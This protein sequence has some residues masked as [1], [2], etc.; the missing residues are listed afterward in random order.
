MVK[1]TKGFKGL[2]KKVLSAIL[3]ASMI[4]TS[5]SFVMAAEPTPEQENAI[6]TEA[7]PEVVD[8]DAATGRTNQKFTKEDVA[9][10]PAIYN[11]EVQHPKVTVDGETEDSGKFHVNYVGDCVNAGTYKVEIT[12]DGDWSGT[13]A[14]EKEFTIEKASI[15][16]ADVEVEAADTFEYN[17]TSQ[18][19]NVVV[20]TTLGSGDEA[21]DYV[22]QDDEYV[23]TYGSDDTGDNKG[24]T[25]GTYTITITA[26]EDSNFKDS[27]TTK[28]EYKIVQTEMSDSLVKVEAEDIP[29]ADFDADALKAAVTVTDIGLD[30]ALEKDEYT[31]TVEDEETAGD[32]GT[33]SFVIE[34]TVNAQ[35]YAGGEVKGQYTVVA[36]ESFASILEGVV[37][38]T[39]YSNAEET[40]VYAEAVENV[41]EQ[42]ADKNV[43]ESEYKIIT[44]ESDWNNV[45]EYTLVVEGQQIYDGQTAEIKVTVSPKAITTNGTDLNQG[46]AVSV[47]QGTHPGSGELSE[48]VVTVTDNKVELVEGTDYV[49]KAVEE[50]GKKYVEITGIGNYTTENKEDKVEVYTKEYTVSKKMY[51]ADPSIY[52][53]VEK[54][55]IAYT[56][57]PITL[58]NSDIVLT[59]TDGSDVI[60]LRP[61]KDYYIVD[62]SYKNNTAPGTATVTVKGM[63]DYTG[64]ITVEFEI[65]GTSFADSFDVSMKK[66]SFAMD[67]L[68]TV[69]KSN[70]V[71]RAKGSTGTY[72]KFDVEYLKD[73]ETYK[74]T[75][76]EPGAYV[77][78]VTS[79]EEKYSGYVDLDFIVLGE[80]VDF[81]VS[82]VEDQVYTGAQ[83]TPAVTVTSKDG[84]TTYKAGE[85]YEVVYG[86]N[87][88]AG[89]NA[90]TVTVNMI[91]EYSGSSTVYFNITKADQTITMTN[92][93]QE[94]DLANGTRTTTSKNCTLKLGFGVPDTMNLSYESSDKSVATVNNGV[95]TYQG[96]GECTI[97]VTA[98]ETN[99][100]KAVSL[101]ITVKVGKVGTPTFTPSVTSKT[102]AKSITVTSST[103]RGA[104]GFEVEYS[105]RPD[106]WR[107]TTVDFENTGSKL[108]RQTIKTY[109]SNKK[110]YIRVRAYQVV[111]GAKVY[112]DWSPV[113]TAT[114]K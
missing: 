25:V 43:K 26:A 55:D 107:S 95:I 19:P 101:P 63:G 100:C 2:S 71:V 12:F 108:Y 77:A 78:R 98:N 53:S 20:T 8:N 103:V 72:G 52:A 99:N 73:G 14:I 35:N 11:G 1:H 16:N 83:I 102:A 22:L 37:F 88:Q 81:N 46:L 34:P 3:A 27:A 24:I 59:E 48:L 54:D 75:K 74:A 51:L 56:G 6:V 80:E 9:I 109:H 114:T 5:S 58:S 110:Y 30:K 44:A 89:N 29:Y 62:T 39:V 85:D 79:T 82:A 13:P 7:A 57:S 84:E 61:G 76:L 60:T 97:T 42:I 104:D 66:D 105:I 17:G 69:V 45:G 68:Q 18:R 32:L 106:W 87:V 111:D 65:V 15:T 64:S 67:T 31:I 91:G 90:G 50:D 93:L 49:Y 36:S 96:V 94:R 28:P 113:K 33:H 92:P 21:Y 10:E 86:E 40:D 38:D 41:K 112:S 47:T 4:M 70:I 23:V